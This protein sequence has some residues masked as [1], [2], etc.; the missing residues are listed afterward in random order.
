[1]TQTEYFNY[2]K[3]IPQLNLSEEFENIDVEDQLYAL[4]QCFMPEGT[5]VDK[6]F[7]PLDKGTLLLERILP[8][9]KATEEAVKESMQEGAIPGYFVPP[10]ISSSEKELKDTGYLFI[11]YMKNFARHLEDEEFVGILNM[12]TEVEILPDRE[13]LEERRDG[14]TDW[15]YDAVSDWAIEET[16]SEVLISILSEAYYSISCDYWLSYYFQYPAFD[17]KPE[18]DL[19]KPYFDLWVKGYICIFNKKGLAITPY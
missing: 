4:F 1:M 7:T 13:S 6:I 18:C 16:D 2:L 11:N 19:F 3:S 15:V 8:I 5:G 9:Y 12:M 14:I 17:S 10:H